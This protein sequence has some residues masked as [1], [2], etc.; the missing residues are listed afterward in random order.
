MNHVGIILTNLPY[1]CFKFRKYSPMSITSIIRPLFL[2]RVNSWQKKAL[3]IEETQRAELA[4]L[5]HRAKGT[6]QGETY[7]YP[8]VTTYE[9]Y[10]QTVPV[11]QYPDIR[12]L[13]ER[14]VD[15][16]KNIPW[17]GTTS[18]PPRTVV[19]HFRRQKQVHTHHRRLVPPHTLSGRI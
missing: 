2:R 13:V 18:P 7:N 19:G 15:G 6:L 11:S 5:L 14:M 8:S 1:L 10:R 17:P 3:R 12:H 9:Q 4:W 16:E